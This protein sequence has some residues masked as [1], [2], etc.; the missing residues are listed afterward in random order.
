MNNKL[1]SRLFKRS[2]WTLLAVFF[3][4]ILAIF[5]IV[6][7]IAKQYEMFVDQFF[8]VTRTV[9]VEA[10]TD[11]PN[12]FQ[13]YTSEFA[14]KDENGNYI[15]ETKSGVNT[16]VL[17]Q[18]RMRAHS[19]EIAEQVNAEGSV[20]LWN[21]ALSVDAQ[22][23]DVCAL[24]LSKGDRISNFGM[25]TVSWVW[26]GIGSGKVEFETE[27]EEKYY[28][29]VKAMLTR[30]EV[31]LIVNDECFKSLE[32]GKAR[33]FGIP[34]G[35]ANDMPWGNYSKAAKDAIP[36]FG[37]AAVYVV[38]RLFG[39]GVDM[40][41]PAKLSDDKDKL[42]LSRNELSVLDGLKE[43][44]KNGD[45]KKIILV[46]NTAGPVNLKGVDQNA[47][48]ACLWVGWG[49][50]MGVDAFTDLLVGNRTPSGHSPDTWAY[51]LKSSPA[52]KNQ[53]RAYNNV[54]AGTPEGHNKFVAYQ[55]GI[56]VG[57]RYYETRYEDVILGRGNA[58]DPV[59]AVMKKTEWDYNAET[60]FPF[61][62]GLSYTSFAYS[63]FSAEKDKKTGD[64]TITLTVHNTG[65]RVGKDAV[66]VYLQK[67]YTQYDIDNKI[68]K[69]SVEL[70]GFTK[71]PDIEP[72]NSATVTVTVPEYEFKS[73]DS[74][75]AGTYIL[76]KGD[77]YLAVGEN[78]HDALNNILAAKN[79][80]V[81][82]GMD[83]NG[84]KTLV[85]KE[86]FAQNDFEKYSKTKT[87]EAV[88]NQFD[89]AD[90][91]R[92]A[93]MEQTLVYLS[94]ND[95]KNTFSS[96][97]S[98]DFK[99]EENVKLV[100]FDKEIKNDPNDEMPTYNTVDQKTG[101]INLIMLKDFEYDDPLWETLLDQLTFD[102]QETLL[103]TCAGGGIKDI[104]APGISQ[105]DGP[106]G[107]RKT[108]FGLPANPVTAATFNPELVERLGV[109]FGT[110]MLQKGN[111]GIYGLGA[112][113][114]RTPWGGRAYEYCSEDGF[115]TGAITS[116]E[117]KG[118]RSMGVILWTKHFALNDQD[119]YRGAGA[120]VWANEQTIREIYLKAFETSITDGYCNGLMTSYNR[121]G[122]SWCGQNEQLLTN[123]LRKEWGFTGI[124][125][126]DACGTNEFM[127]GNS[128]LHAF[129][130]MA[131]QDAWMGNFK[132]GALKPYYESRNATV[133]KA[134]RESAHRIL[135]TQL[136]SLMMNGVSSS[137]KFINITPGWE[138]ALL[139][140]KVVSGIL[141]GLCLGMVAASWTL[142]YLDRKKQTS[143]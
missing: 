84:D 18:E 87:G 51:D 3:M 50:H 39:E 59:G 82:D 95:W 71:T 57:Y 30:E 28:T 99:G 56:Y 104:A 115:L 102:Q 7:P 97:A 19:R 111:G 21:N 34:L 131:G 64:Y 140:V 73:Y 100:K 135:Y 118:M 103:R 86:T 117:S 116:Y 61:G 49:G 90:V 107:S 119:L 92:N 127:G 6:T 62:Y 41:D 123:V 72:G 89:M 121:I 22:G 78:A 1:K 101:K 45:I 44:K 129:A 47:V 110:E 83:Y 53:P 74:Y 16:Q 85:Y 23:N 143:T 79:Y 67:P 10:D 81:A 98:L 124:T 114:H 35:E 17:D 15:L 46:L 9:P 52:S 88:V 137:T 55:E 93:G 133:C 42:S 108:K 76:E 29:D 12:D 113:I 109:V 43:L 54:A 48:D 68:E 139:A 4:L 33:G 66:Q 36:Q 122:P 94:R 106:M 8:N 24:P 70:V 142:R 5:I 96:G 125:I 63:G 13:Y 69:S 91:N 77:Y 138:S 75:G 132:E 11:N 27:A 40:S 128:S 14:T 26:S 65:S 60:A 32:N 105:A 2:M 134:V 141:M 20:L 25:G 126:T 38:S 130:N 31:G 80:T 136:H 37:D 112:N 58:S 120:M